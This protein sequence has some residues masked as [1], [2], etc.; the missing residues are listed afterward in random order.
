MTSQE[1][2]RVLD[3]LL[4]QYPNPKTD[5]NHESPWQLLVATMLSAQCTDKRVN[6]ITP[7]IFSR[8]PD[9][10]SLAHVS[11]EEVESLIWDCGLYHTKAKNLVKTAQIIAEHY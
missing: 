5:L 6:I 11:V 1:I 7:R 3:A 2:E 9:A 4:Q 8:Y 10:R